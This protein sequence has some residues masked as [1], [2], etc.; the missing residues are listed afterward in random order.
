MIFSTPAHAV[1]WV[2]L[3]TSSDKTDTFYVDIHSIKENGG[4]VYYWVLT[5]ALKPNEFGVW[6]TKQF[7]ELDCNIPVKQ[8]N[9]SITLYEGQMGEGTISAS[10]NETTEWRYEPP[11]SMGAKVVDTICYVISVR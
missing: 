11:N 3:V 10:Q 6:S 2:K 1:E 7:N 8:R 9:L 4:Y 5:D